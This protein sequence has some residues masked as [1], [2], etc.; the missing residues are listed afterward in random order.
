MVPPD[1]LLFP[2][3]TLILVPDKPLLDRMLTTSGTD[4]EKPYDCSCRISADKE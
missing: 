4:M 3:L 1:S 2:I